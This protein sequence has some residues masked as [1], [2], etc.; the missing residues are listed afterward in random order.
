MIDIETNRILTK[1]ITKIC[2]K[3]KDYYDTVDASIEISEHH[4]TISYHMYCDH[5]FIND[6][7]VFFVYYD[8]NINEHNRSFLIYRV[9]EKLNSLYERSV[10]AWADTMWEFYNSPEIK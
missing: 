5:L 9:K 2:K 8:E 6:T 1:N 4:I 7:D 10:K 3:L